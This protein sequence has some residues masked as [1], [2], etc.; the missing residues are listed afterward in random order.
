MNEK[1]LLTEMLRMHEAE[2]DMSIDFATENYEGL[3]RL[4][5]QGLSCYVVTK[6]MSGNVRLRRDITG[7]LTPAGVERAKAIISR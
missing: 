6:V 1:E 4:W 2:E 7:I 5:Q 3:K